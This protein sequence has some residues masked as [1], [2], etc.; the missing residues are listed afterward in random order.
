M[1]GD[2]RIGFN[3]QSRLRAVKWSLLATLCGFFVLQLWRPFYFLNDDNMSG[4]YPSVLDMSRR[5]WSGQSPLFIPQIHGGYQVLNDPGGLSVL[6]PFLLV[7]SPLA[8]TP[9]HIALT[10]TYV[11]L[12]LMLCAYAMAQLLVLVRERFSPDLTDARV[13]FL[14]FSYTFSIWMIVTAPN[15]LNFIANQAA[16]PILFLGLFRQRRRTG[17]T[18]VACAVLHSMLSG[19]L[20]SFILSILF[21]LL[22]LGVDSAVRKEDRAE[23][24]LRLLSGAA[25]AGLIV[26]PVL[27]PALR[28]FLGMSRSAGG[29]GAATGDTSG[30]KHAFDALL[31]MPLPV[32]LASY[33]VG[34]FASLFGKFGLL[35]LP[36]G[37][38][39]AIVCTPASYWVFHSLRARRKLQSAEI[40]C[41]VTAA[42]IVLCVVRPPWLSTVFSLVPLLRSTRIPFREIFAFLFFIHLFIAL[43]PVALPRIALLGTNA[44]GALFYT[45][46][47]VLFRPPAFTPMALDRMLLISGQAEPYWAK[48]R[49]MMPRG[50]RM[51]PVIPN[52][53]QYIQRV[54][55]PWTLMN[56]F[57]YPAASGIGSATGY[58]IRGMSGERLHGV[59]PLGPIGAF[60]ERDVPQLRK[61]DPKLCFFVLR[62]RNPVRIELWT[63]Q[64]KRMLPVPTLPRVN[65]KDPWVIVGQK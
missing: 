17:I 23:N 55:V 47:L 35:A 32:F 63:P 53:F 60:Y 48:V 52:N 10:D 59:R 11:F 1:P 19:H 30:G 56:A 44:I 28:G 25:V 46:S 42:F 8:L 49:P 41:L 65:G 12:H 6:N 20:N 3:A 31:A 39:S 5:L 27:I 7:V 57:N 61:A 29:A 24:W 9:W 16:L 45:V 58:V 22:W 50:A 54:E 62:S 40:A 36:N 4:W 15:W 14:T 51:V 26:L 18:L 43:R 34:L 64:G 38:S 21:V 13:A 37:I 33:F 2:A